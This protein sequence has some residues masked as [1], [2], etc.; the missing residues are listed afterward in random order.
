VILIVTLRE[1]RHHACF[2]VPRTGLPRT[3]AA[4]VVVFT[5]AAEFAAI[6]LILIVRR[7]T[8]PLH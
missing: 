2:A 1:A 3:A 4:A 7:R 6:P 5:M 8:A